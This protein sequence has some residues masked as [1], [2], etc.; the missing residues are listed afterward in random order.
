MAP[1][2]RIDIVLAE[3][4]SRIHAF[5]SRRCGNPED[6]EDLAQ[7]AMCAIVS[8]Y[9]RFAQRSSL[10]TWVYAICRNVYTNYQYQSARQQK[11]AAAARETRH[12]ARQSELE[13]RL[14]LDSLPSSDRKLYS[15]FYVQ[16]LT[17]RQIAL[18]LGK[19]EGTV[20]YLLHRL[21]KRI[22]E[23]LA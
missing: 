17:I 3:F 23:E 22:R 13:I 5:F 18:M 20:K 8:G 7:E 1:L 21:R 14:E 16:V 2:K 6:I 12:E 11:A 4:E 9:H 10:S 19:P 15:L